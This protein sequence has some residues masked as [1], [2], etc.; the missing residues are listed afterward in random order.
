MRRGCVVRNSQPLRCSRAT[1]AVQTTAFS[2]LPTSKSRTTFSPAQVSPRAITTTAPLPMTTP[3]SI[4]PKKAVF[5]RSRSR[6]S[7]I[8]AAVASIQWREGGVLYSV[9]YV[10]GGKLAMIALADSAID[11]GPR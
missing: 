4:S 5:V 8:L 11:A 1:S 10:L 2:L 7:P 6:S 9:Q 3:S